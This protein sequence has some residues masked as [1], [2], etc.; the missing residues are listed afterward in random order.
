MGLLN[1]FWFWPHKW[2]SPPPLW[3]DYFWDSEEGPLR[4]A[5]IV[6]LELSSKLKSFSPKPFILAMRIN[7][8]LISTEKS[9]QSQRYTFWSP[10][11][12]FFQFLCPYLRQG[13]GGWYN[14]SLLDTEIQHVVSVEFKD[15]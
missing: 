8:F 9:Q 10:I 11:L 14:V 12:N 4:V 2:K 7:G 6:Y 13:R 15:K 5:Q 3:T 1:N